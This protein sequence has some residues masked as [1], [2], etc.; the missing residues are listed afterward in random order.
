VHPGTDAQLVQREEPDDEVVQIED[1]MAEL[2]QE[3]GARERNLLAQVFDLQSR[4]LSYEERIDGLL[5]GDA[6]LRRARDDSVLG[7]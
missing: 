5:S 3:H 2:E 4:A 1:T 7:S 6:E